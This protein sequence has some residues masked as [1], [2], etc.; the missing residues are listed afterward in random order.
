MRSPCSSRAAILRVPI[1]TAASA[2]PC[3]RGDTLKLPERS[4]RSE[5]AF[6][7]ASDFDEPL[8]NE[9]Q[10][11][12]NIHLHVRAWLFKLK[13][14]HAARDLPLGVLLEPD[15]L[16]EVMGFV[17]E[18]RSARGNRAPLFHQQ[19][20]LPKPRKFDHFIGLLKQAFNGKRRKRRVLDFH[21]HLLRHSAA[22]FWLLKLWP[23][24]HRV[25]GCMFRDRARTLASLRDSARLR[26]ALLC[27][28]NSR[29]S[30]LQAMTFLLGHRSSAVSV[31][32][33]LHCLDWHRGDSRSDPP[34]AGTASD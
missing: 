10:E 26:Q 13:T 34:E 9:R 22:N 30:D 25:A 15:E 7:R 1:C 28:G 17:A 21:Y 29:S 23:S 6:L 16:T 5:C 33:Y 19:C 27:S 32:H 14:S 8:P 4:E 18:I 2:K 24:L 31:H 3:S 20:S 11:N 12:A